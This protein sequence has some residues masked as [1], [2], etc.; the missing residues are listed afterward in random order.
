M[1]VS[2]SPSLPD[3]DD[4]FSNPHKVII[5][6]ITVGV[7]TKIDK[8]LIE[9]SG[10]TKASLL[11]WQLIYILPVA[12]LTNDFFLSNFWIRTFASKTDKDLWIGVSIAATVTLV[13]LTLV[14]STGF[15]AVW[16]GAFDPSNPDQDGSVA[17]FYLLEQLPTWTV[18]IVLVMVVSLSTAAF[19]SLQS[20]MVSSASNDLFRNRLNIWWIRGAVV[21]IIFP[22]VVLALRAPSILQIYLISDLVS[23]SVIPVLVLGLNDAFYFWRGFEVVVGGL[24][25]I[26]TVFIF[27]TIYYGDALKGAQLILLEQGLYEN[28]WSAFGA[29]V[30]APVGGMLWGFG[31]LALRL[32]YQWVVAKK[33]G[34]RF[35]ALDR[36]PRDQGEGS[37][38]DDR[39]S[40]VNAE[41]EATEGLVT[42]DSK[43]KFF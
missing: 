25:G 21:A 41:S 8:S 37:T 18:G 3:V 1:L 12:V 14:G 16:S 7:E 32:S 29:F 2:V 42:I 23:A 15:I 5:A 31:A 24:G 10:L 36:P 22:V 34:T 33:T 30:A 26:L 35:D 19:D 6:T 17:F 20:A 40:Q 43:G 38:G 27:G 13:V 9:P 11:G 28:D 39:A 4:N